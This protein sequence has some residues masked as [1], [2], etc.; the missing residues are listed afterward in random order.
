MTKDWVHGV[1]HSPVCQILLQIVMRAVITLRKENWLL[2][3]NHTFLVD[4]AQQPWLAASLGEGQLLFETH[5]CQVCWT[6]WTSDQGSGQVLWVY[7][8][9]KTL[10]PSR[11]LPLMG[12]IAGFNMVLLG[13]SLHSTKTRARWAEGLHDELNGHVFDLERDGLCQVVLCPR[14]T[15]R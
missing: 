9:R 15:M 1:G 11:S 14:L 2:L 6:G 10:P 3:H 7:T 13:G 4:W 5:E 12:G 8:G